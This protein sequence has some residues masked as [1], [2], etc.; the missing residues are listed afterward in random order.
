MH[1]KIRL[2][3]P[4]ILCVCTCVCAR[5]HMCVSACVRV[6]VSMCRAS[7]LRAIIF[8]RMIYKLICCMIFKQRQGLYKV[9]VFVFSLFPCVCVCLL[10][11]F[12]FVFPVD[13]K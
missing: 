11:L 9:F 2:A 7:V 3:N 6:G 10:L 5:A 1:E 4:E 8:S 13:R 12:S